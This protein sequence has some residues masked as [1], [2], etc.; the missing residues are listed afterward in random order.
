MPSTGSAENCSL[1]GRFGLRRGGQHLGSAL[2]FLSRD[3]SPPVDARSHGSRDVEAVWR[4]RDR[5]RSPRPTEFGHSRRAF[6]ADCKPGARSAHV[7][8]RNSAPKSRSV[9]PNRS[10]NRKRAAAAGARFARDWRYGKLPLPPAR[11][12]GFGAPTQSTTPERHP[13]RPDTAIARPAPPA[14]QPQ[15]HRETLRMGAPILAVIA[16]NP[17][18]RTAAAQPVVVE[19]PGPRR[20]RPWS[21]PAVQLPLAF[22]KLGPDASFRL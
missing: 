13:S 17:S 4:H 5:R 1:R 7:L 6:A 15:R 10:A 18:T 19:E 21:R 16:S 2:G 12:P 8:G 9:S 22:R 14:R 11:P 3:T 20:Q